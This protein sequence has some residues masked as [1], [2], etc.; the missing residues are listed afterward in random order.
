MLEENKYVF[1]NIPSDA[2]EV[3]LKNISTFLA[4]SSFI[5][6]IT[7]KFLNTVVNFGRKPFVYG[8]TIIFF[9][10]V[11]ENVNCPNEDNPRGI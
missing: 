1:A 4:I 7:N 5:D 11:P 9:K 2:S 8:T 10:N 6:M 3:L